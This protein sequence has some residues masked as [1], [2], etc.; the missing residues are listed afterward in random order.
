MRLFFFCLFLLASVADSAQSR[1]ASPV[2]VYTA[3]RQGEIEPCGCKVKQIGGLDRMAGRIAQIKVKQPVF[4]VDAGNT[5]F[6][7]PSPS[8]NRR[9]QDLRKAELIAKSYRFMGLQAFSPGPRDFAEGEK[10]LAALIEI[11]GA[12]LVSANLRFQ[13]AKAKRAIFLEAEGPRVGVTGASFFSGKTPMGVEVEPV[14]KSLEQLF[15]TTQKEKIDQWILLSHLDPQA[16]KEIAESF[17]GLWIINSF[18]LDFQESPKR[19]AQS[20]VFEVGLEG[21]RLGEVEIRGSSHEPQGARLTE[22]GK[23]LLGSRS[24]REAM[25]QYYKNLE[26]LPEGP[27]EK[28]G[29]WVANAFQCKSCHEAQ[30][31]FWKETPHSTAALALYEKGQQDDPSCVG[32]HSLGYQEA[33]GFSQFATSIQSQKNKKGLAETLLKMSST[34]KDRAQQQKTYWKELERL[35]QK[36]KV[37]KLFWGVQCEHCHESR[38][39]HLR[40]G[41]KVGKGVSLSACQSCHRSPNAPDFDPK[42]IVKVAC[43]K[44]KETDV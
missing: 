16:E 3:S 27:E 8:K 40:T 7:L 19:V 32:C 43:P 10:R 24:V 39:E 1:K 17:P 25:A 26:T 14:K 22:L 44:T 36:E 21:Q 28:K 18:S 34:P 37:T 6:P 29:S 30:F 31:E 41:A 9:A 35:H 33:G 4:F 11:S 42:T 23:E 20:Y 38:V 13:T 5:F 2:L 12:T 15:E